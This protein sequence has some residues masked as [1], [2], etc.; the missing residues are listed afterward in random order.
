MISPGLVIAGSCDHHLVVLSV[1][2]SMLAAWAVL[3]LAGRV[4]ATRGGARL[5]WLIGGATASGIGTWSMHYTGMLAF[6]LPVPVQY[7]W[8]TVMLSLLPALCAAAIGLLLVTRWEI[9]WFRALASGGSK[10]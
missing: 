6:S 3:D 7:D 9:G 10:Q 8:P 1:L 5:A 2:I 4:A